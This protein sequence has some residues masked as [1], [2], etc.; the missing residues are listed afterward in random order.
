MSSRSIN[1]GRARTVEQPVP[2][3][4]N[5]Q[6]EHEVRWLEVS[7]S[8]DDGAAIFSGPRQRGYYAHASV[9]VEERRPGSGIVGRKFELFKSGRKAFLA[10]AARFSQKQLEQQAQRFSWNVAAVETLVDAA[11]VTAGFSLPPGALARALNIGDCAD[12]RTLNHDC[13]R[14]REVPQL[15]EVTQ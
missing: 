4:Y 12:C 15:D 6:R 1:L 14:H 9:V 8:Y 10:P 13:P 3:E 2:D 7:V 5:P 11:L